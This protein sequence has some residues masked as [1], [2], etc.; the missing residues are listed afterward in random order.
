LKGTWPDK[1]SYP[2]VPRV[3]QPC[4][5]KKVHKSSTNIYHLNLE[6][7]E[8]LEDLPQQLMRSI[9]DVLV[10]AEISSN[11]NFLDSDNNNDDEGDTSFTRLREM[12]RFLRI[13]NYLLDDEPCN[14]DFIDRFDGYE[15]SWP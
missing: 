1:F 11:S 15:L 6:V 8:V 10:S 14:D 7:G 4:H 2:S 13:N 12:Q 9:A 5:D 3:G